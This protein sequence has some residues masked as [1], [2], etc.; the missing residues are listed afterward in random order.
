MSIDLFSPA[1][2]QDPYPAYAELRRKAPVHHDPRRNLWLIGRYAD[3]ERVL[4]ESE[5]FSSRGTSRENLL[6]GADPPVHTRVRNVVKRAFTPTRITALEGMIRSLARELADRMA[7]RGACEGIED[8]AVPLPL[9]VVASM[10]GIDAARLGD[11][12]RW[13]DARFRWG[14]ATLSEAQRRRAEQEILEC[15]A[16]FAHHIQ[17]MARDRSGGCIPEFLLGTDDGDRL[18]SSEVLDVALLLL[19]SDPILQAR[20]RTSPDLI[21]TFIEEMLRYEAPIQRRSRVTTCPTQIGAVCLPRGARVEVLIGSANRDPD[22]FPDA[23][24]FRI[25]RQPNRHLSFGSGPHFCLGAKLARLEVS[26]LLETLLQRATAFARAKPAERIDFGSSLAVRGPKRLELT[27]APSTAK[28]VLATEAARTL[29]QVFPAK[30][31]SALAFV[32]ALVRWDDWYVTKISLFLVCMYYAALSGPRLDARLMGEMAVLLVL[33]C[34]Y[35]SFG[36]MI[37]DFSDRAADRAAG[38]RNALAR[39]SQE[40]APVLVLVAGVSGLLPAILFYFGRPDVIALTAGAYVLATLYSLP[41][42]RLKERGA[43]RLVAAAAAQ[44]TLPA[45]IIFDAMH[46]WDLTA[47]ALCVLST[48]IGLRNILEHQVVD[49]QNDARAGI[50]T[51]GTGWG[52]DFIR[53]LIKRTVYPLELATLGVAVLTMGT[54]VP[55]VWALAGLYAIWLE[56]CRRH[57]KQLGSSMPPLSYEFPFG[58]YFVCWPLVLATMLSVREPVFLAVLALNILWLSHALRLLI[59]R[60]TQLFGAGPDAPG[61]KMPLVKVPT[62]VTAGDFGSARPSARGPKHVKSSSGA[63]PVRVRQE[64]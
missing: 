64:I 28:R 20:L 3:V 32:R 13:A 11:L 48:L 16:F 49:A 1:V 39:L 4:S 52:V 56:V 38:K 6:V 17:R 36:H 61:S 27:F 43:L 37:N 18:T 5:I 63:L 60:A 12:R 31:S 62:R 8:L 25:E 29:P 55:Q 58:F 54:S 19:A 47:V 21:P 23:D 15:R 44:R 59:G 33:L 45:V 57:L 14:N 50:H 46:A 7:A 22:Q 34:G 2:R 41:P 30:L 42:A 24:Q 35:A 40:R 10:L 53:R 9:S 51:F 26:I